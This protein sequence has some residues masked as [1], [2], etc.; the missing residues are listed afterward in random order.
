MVRHEHLYE[1]IEAHL[2]RSDEVFADRVVAER[3]L[4]GSTVILCTVS[5]LSN[6]ALVDAGIYHLVPV[7]RLVVDEASQ[8]DSFEF[9]VRSFAVSLSRLVFQQ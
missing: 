9:M 7:E 1:A 6:P 2:I 8:I 4:G 3:F 5:M